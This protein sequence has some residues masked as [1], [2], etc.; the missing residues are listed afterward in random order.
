MVRGSY[1]GLSLTYLP[2][3][4]EGEH[5]LGYLYRCMHAG[6]HVRM[7]DLAT[8]LVQRLTIQPPWTVASHLN[9][10]AKELWP[11]FPSGEHIL[12]EHTCLPA[13]LSFVAPEKVPRVL[14]YV[15]DGAAQ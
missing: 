9:R 4:M 7:K 5:I 2:P 12:R 6:Q 1:S 15:L 13:H 14:A 10:L 8:T 11:V 3:V